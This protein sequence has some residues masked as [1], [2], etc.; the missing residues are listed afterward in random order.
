[1]DENRTQAA[2]NRLAAKL[3]ALDLDDDEHAVLVA[4]LGAG[5]AS[6]EPT[7]EVS[8]FALGAHSL[9][10]PAGHRPL[11]DAPAPT[12]NFTCEVGGIYYFF[13]HHG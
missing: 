10:T 2:A 8:G 3:E 9:F 1:M 4:M 11:A 13:N 7:E 6:I 12:E 5:A